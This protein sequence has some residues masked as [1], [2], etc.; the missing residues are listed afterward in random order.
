MDAGRIH[1]EPAK[2][3]G[4][5]LAISGVLPRPVEEVFVSRVKPWD[6]C[7][8]GGFKC[9]QM[10]QSSLAPE[11]MSEP[12]GFFFCRRLRLIMLGRV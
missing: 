6:I 12:V 3:L 4:C 1:L 7:P 11:N 2:F 5:L 10:L 9:L 8:S